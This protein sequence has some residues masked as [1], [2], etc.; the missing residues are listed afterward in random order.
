MA[1]S[2]ADFKPVSGKEDFSSFAPAKPAAPYYGASKSKYG[3]ASAP[4]SHP[5][6]DPG[7][8][9]DTGLSFVDNMALAQADNPKE[10]RKYLSQVYGAGNV[11]NTSD[12]GFAVLKD[13]KTIA[14]SGGGG[15]KNFVAQTVGKTPTLAGMAVGAA[16]GGAMGVMGGPWGVGIGALGGAAIG[17]MAGKT[18][19]DMAKAAQGRYDKSGAEHAQSLSTA[20]K[21]GLE[22]EAGGRVVGKVVSKALR[23]QAPPIISGTTPETR[24]MTERVLQGG[25]RPAAQESMPNMK[26]IQFM[27]A[28]AAKTVGPVKAQVAANTKYIKTRVGSLLR[29]SG[30]PES[31]IDPT[32]RELESGNS[33]VPTAEV[34]AHVKAAVTAHKEM[35]ETQVNT[36]MGAAEDL[37]QRQLTHLDSITRRFKTN[38]LGVDVAE[39]IVTARQDFGKAFSK[40]YDK[41]DSL[42]GDA[43]LVPT[44]LVNKTAKDILAR[45]P[46]ATR[47]GLTKDLA[48]VGIDLEPAAG[49]APAKSPMGGMGATPLPAPKVEAKMSFG[50][51]QR[52]RTLLHEKMEGSLTPGVTAHEFGELLDSINHGITSAAKDPAAAPAVR[53]LQEADRRYGQGLAKFKDNTVTRLVNDMKA[54]IPPDAETVAKTILQPGYEA[55]VKVVKGLVDKQ[56]WQKVAGADYSNI[57][58]ASTDETGNVSGVKFLGQVTQR[59]KLMEEVY[60]KRAA[61]EITEMA[62]ALAA[63]DG[64]LPVEAMAPGTFRETLTQLKGE[65]K[66]LDDFMKKNALSMLTRGRQA[67]EAAYAW[68]VKPENGTFLGNAVKLLGEDSPVVAELR[69]SALKELLI[70]TKFSIAQSRPQD[71]LTKALGEYTAS[72]QKVL[73]PNGM[74]DDIH[75]L[76]KETEFLMAK[77][78]DE[79][80]ASFAAGAVLGISKLTT[81]I[82]AQVSIGLYQ[83]ILSSPGMIRYLALGL[84]SPPGP[85][86]EKSK[87]LLMNIIRNGAISPDE[88]KEQ[89]Q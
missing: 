19:E 76:G 57:I 49:A 48:K 33:S 51:A 23:G 20:A 12:G 38:E 11:K 14:A 89:A 3:G 78:S 64:A 26:H 45:A 88:Q 81:R 36:T 42:V 68:L 22:G 5:H 62:R 25:G 66:A 67:P 16:E 44:M 41:I 53:M 77:L 27:E 43:K 13:G 63:R 65:E 7:V 60:G 73:F 29:D 15:F 74:S 40:V 24:A 18:V 61:G 85:I 21:E 6:H 59:A 8:D 87:Q 58:K 50:Q 10:V 52:A 37:A 31:H 2:F 30:I 71:A 72:Q 82:P 75:L 47:D 34:G 17:A 35:L 32:I 84:H 80:K 39:G 56:T 79:S 83:V 28:L 46:Q 55:R 86:R 54:G 70:K 1:E 4:A 69:Q 9:Y